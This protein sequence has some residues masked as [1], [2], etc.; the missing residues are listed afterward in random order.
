M[1][2]RFTR[3]F[4]W[5]RNLEWMASLIE[6]ARERGLAV[7]GQMGIGISW[8]WDSP[9]V[10]VLCGIGILGTILHW[11]WMRR[12]RKNVE[13]DAGAPPLRF[14][15]PILSAIEHVI[16][17]APALGFT[18]SAAQQRAAFRRICEQAANGHVAIRGCFGRFAP[19]EQIAPDMVKFS[20]P[21]EVVVGTE[22]GAP[23]GVSFEL[24][25]PGPDDRAVERKDGTF[26]GYSR[27]F[28]PK[29]QILKLWPNEED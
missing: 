29:S 13:S 22:P 1:A 4:E 27:L 11:H 7:L 28:V 6:L 23:E 19:P 5:L 10:P 21:E 9:A 14:D 15:M 18:S 16:V 25:I 20:R 12:K 26:Y 2:N 24:L 3:L 8:F 17:S